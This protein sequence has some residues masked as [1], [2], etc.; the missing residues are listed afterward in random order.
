MIGAGRLQPILERRVEPGPIADQDGRGDRAG[1]RDRERRYG[2]RRRRERRREDPRPALRSTSLW[3]SVARARRSSR[4][5]RESDRDV[6]RQAAGRARRH[7]GTAPASARWPASRQL[8]PARHVAAQVV[9]EAPGHGQHRV[10]LR[11]CERH[12]PLH[13]SLPA[14]CAWRRR[15]LRRPIAGGPRSPLKSACS[16]SAAS[17]GL[18]ARRSIAAESVQV[19]KSVPASAAASTDRGQRAI[20]QDDRRDRQARRRRRG[21]PAAG[22]SM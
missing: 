18:R 16:T 8:R 7:S 22:R 2:G 13:A 10:A 6:P 1:R 21:R 4:C 14:R 3:R 11:C 17:G 15:R 5:R 19:L 9:G 20:D 12:P